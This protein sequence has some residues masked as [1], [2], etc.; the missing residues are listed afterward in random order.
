MRQSLNVAPDLRRRI[1]SARQIIAFRNI[2][3]HGYASIANDVVWDVLQD[4]LPMLY[5]EIEELLR[6]SAASSD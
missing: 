1:S 6:E 4:D 3:I 5:H 2:L